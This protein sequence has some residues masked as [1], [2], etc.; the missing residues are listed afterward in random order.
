MGEWA[1]PDQSGIIAEFWRR[2]GHP[3]QAQLDLL[4]KV[5]GIPVSALVSS[6]D[7]EDF[8]IAMFHV[9]RHRNTFVFSDDKTIKPSI[10]FVAWN[11]W[12][13]AHDLVAWSPRDGWA[14]TWLGRAG[15]LGECD[16]QAP[17]VGDALSV[18]LNIADWLRAGRD[19]F[20]IVDKNKGARLLEG[21]TV[22]AFDLEE[23]VKLRKIMERP[24]ARIVVPDKRENRVAA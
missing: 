9:E 14:G 24:R 6:V 2:S 17:R 12:G 13:T 10:G 23:G 3:S 8:P 5:M 15:G 4:T 11:E 20:A 22:K 18:F 7:G 21:M 16:L 19:G 1:Y